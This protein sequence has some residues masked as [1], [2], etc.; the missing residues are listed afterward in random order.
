M[1][2]IILKRYSGD[3]AVGKSQGG[4]KMQALEKKLCR[5]MNDITR[6]T[7]RVQRPGPK[8][9]RREGACELGGQKTLRA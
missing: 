4:Q 3:A 9:K 1:T 6:A 7:K 2:Q 5:T 8:R